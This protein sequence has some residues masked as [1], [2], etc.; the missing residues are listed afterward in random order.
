MLPSA[1]CRAIRPDSASSWKTCPTLLY[2][3]Q[4]SVE[5]NRQ[6]LHSALR[7]RALFALGSPASFRSI[8]SGRSSRT[9][10]SDGYSNSNQSSHPDSRSNAQI[11]AFISPSTSVILRGG[12]M[13]DGAHGFKTG[14]AL[15]SSSGL[16]AFWKLFNS[17]AVNPSL[18]FDA[19]VKLPNP[20]LRYLSQEQIYSL[21]SKL[22]NIEKSDEAAMLRYLTVIDD[23]K[24]GRVPVPRLHWNVAISF[25]AKCYRKLTDHDLQSGLFLWRE[26]EKVA[27]MPADATTF[28][29]LF[30]LA[31]NSDMAHLPLMILKEMKRRRVSLD[32]FSYVNLIT[33]YGRQGN[34]SGIR[35][36]YRELV[37]AGEV[38]DIVVLNAIMTALIEAG[39]PQAAEDI[40][41]HLT[42]P[43]IRAKQ[44]QLREKR[45]SRLH[46]D[47]K[48]LRWI[49]DQQGFD[50]GIG[51]HQSP[52]APNFIS[53]AIFID[54][55]ASETADLGKILSILRDLTECGIGA[56]TSIF[57]SL[58]KGFS[59]HGR[60][61]HSPWTLQKLNAVFEAFI[62][63]GYRINRDATLWCL[64]ACTILAGKERAEVMWQVVKDRWTK[65]GG[66][67]FE[68][69]EVAH[70]LSKMKPR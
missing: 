11:P 1:L 43:S 52:P 22:S 50:T 12:N 23:M 62:D 64:R 33:Y 69:V 3:F 42:R 20:R 35:S 63:G 2:S 4:A 37:D 38:V 24:T 47:V 29:I 10:D 65:Q 26:M 55:H 66:D 40:L 57:Q 36:T 31:A 16:T 60:V 44:T 7:T 13:T 58:F 32:R 51:M 17:T 53:F 19:Y 21:L 56:E 49:L 39:E 27:G 41:V 5:L 67:S 59:L 14:G 45:K 34:G 48:E 9:A 18:L 46:K 15:P 70:R 6:S 54:Y 30:H 61:N 28:N 68:M 8:N 25:V